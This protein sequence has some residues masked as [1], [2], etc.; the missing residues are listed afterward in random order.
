MDG[1]LRGVGDSISGFWDNAASS[2]AD[3]VDGVV[4]SANA[5]LPGGILLL[6][7]VILV[8]LVGFVLVTR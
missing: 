3:A 8:G 2:V 1:L 7:A 4:D 6:V 5:A